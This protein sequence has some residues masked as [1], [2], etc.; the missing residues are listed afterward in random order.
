MPEVT[1]V[2]RFVQD[3]RFLGYGVPGEFFIRPRM[4]VQVVEPWPWLKK[5]EPKPVK[6]AIPMERVIIGNSGD[7]SCPDCDKYHFDVAGFG[8]YR[9]LDRSVKCKRC[10]MKFI[11]YRP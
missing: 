3:G 10:G 5:P 11:A 7:V 6:R 4:G 9:V 2:R 1:A 8:R